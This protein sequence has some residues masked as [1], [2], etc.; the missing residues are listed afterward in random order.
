MRRSRELDAITVAEMTEQGIEAVE[1]SCL[2]CGAGWRPPITF[3]P[4]ATTLSQ[5]AALM[6]CPNCGGRDVEVAA[7]ILEKPWMTH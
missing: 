5:I 3:L 2:R 4:P 6:A 1:A 7:P